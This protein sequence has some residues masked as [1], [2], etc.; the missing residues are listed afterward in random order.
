MLTSVCIGIC[1]VGAVDTVAANSWQSARYALRR[2][3]TPLLAVATTPLARLLVR[4]GRADKRH[5]PK[6][7]P[8]WLSTAPIDTFRKSCLRSSTIRPCH[9]L[10]C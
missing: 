2:E 10:V 8:E 3:T 5:S 4:G 1:I 7:A 9:R 6:I